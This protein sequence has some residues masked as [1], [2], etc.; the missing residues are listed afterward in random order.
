MSTAN[1]ACIREPR[2]CCRRSTHNALIRNLKTQTNILYITCNFHSL[3]HRWSYI[4]KALSLWGVARLWL[5]TLYAKSE[6]CTDEHFYSPNTHYSYTCVYS[7]IESCS[8]IKCNWIC[9]AYR[10]HAIALYNWIQK[11]RIHFWRSLDQKVSW[12]FG[13]CPGFSPCAGNL[14]RY[15]TSYTSQL[16]L[17]IPPWV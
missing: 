16:N 2:T 11:Y 4:L 13:A 8:H 15:L 6:Y 14:S 9:C 17:A 10:Q 3:C 12:R 1:P 5:V 7:L